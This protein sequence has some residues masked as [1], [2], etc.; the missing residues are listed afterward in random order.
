M[1]FEKIILLNLILLFHIRDPRAYLAVYLFISKMNFMLSKMSFF[2]KNLYAIEL[3][4]TLPH[5]CINFTW[6]WEKRFLG[7]NT[8][9]IVFCKSILSPLLFY[10]YISYMSLCDVLYF[11]LCHKLVFR[12][13]IWRLWINWERT[14]KK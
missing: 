8:C 7:L 6:F 1:V 13:Y 9:P 10:M 4:S 14:F 2:Q 3:V 11:Y 5:K 12:Y